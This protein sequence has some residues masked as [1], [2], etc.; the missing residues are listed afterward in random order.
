MVASEKPPLNPE[1]AFELASNDPR[2]SFVRVAFE[3]AYVEAVFPVSLVQSCSFGFWITRCLTDFVSLVLV[4][5]EP[6]S[7]MVCLVGLMFVFLI[8][9]VLF[10]LARED[11]HVSPCAWGITGNFSIW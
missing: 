4:V 5:M 2:D 9:G 1:D 10:L 3:E 6:S 7:L 11:L 8:Y